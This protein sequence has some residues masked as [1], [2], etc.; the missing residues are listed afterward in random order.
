[1]LV[2]GCGGSSSG[3]SADNGPDS[4]AKHDANHPVDA[5][6][7]AEA[8]VRHDTGVALDTG[9]VASGSSSTSSHSSNASSHGLSNGSTGGSSSYSGSDASTDSGEPTGANVAPLIVDTGPTGADSINTPFVT[10]TICIPGTSTCQTIDH[11]MVDTGSSGVHIIASVLNSTMVLPQVMASTGSPLAECQTYVDSEVWGGIRT[12]DVK[13]AGETAPGIPI[14]VIADPGIPK[15]PSSCGKASTVTDT[16]AEYGANGLVGINQVIA[17][18]GPDCAATPA[19]PAGY[20]SCSGST[21]TPVAVPVANQ[22]P[23]PIAFFKADNNGAIVSFAPTTIPATGGATLSGSLIFGI[24]TQANNALGSAT[25]LTT[26]DYGNLTTVFNGQTLNESYFDTGT[27]S[28]DFA[29]SAIAVCG[30]SD[31][32]AG[33]DCPTSTLNLTAVN[34]GLNGASKSASFTIVDADSMSQTDAVL[35]DLGGPAD[36]AGAFAWGFPFFIGRNIYVALAGAS[37]PGGAG[38]FYAY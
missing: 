32:W 29:D 24:G 16:V 17:D 7:G 31:F 9:V 30:Q 28:Y 6:R 15:V 2:I 13:I 34:K 14:Q 8:T 5:F 12:A 25:V 11:V 36:E 38:P 4:G 21:C 35:P 22:V 27:P 10:I 18:C 33:Q 19:Q 37:T 3:G 20:Y 23:N 1:M 26:D